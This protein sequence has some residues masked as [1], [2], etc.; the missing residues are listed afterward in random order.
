M[1]NANFIAMVYDT[2]IRN[3]PFRHHYESSE[4][5]DFMSGEDG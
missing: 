4:N 5:A 2:L 1:V 3:H